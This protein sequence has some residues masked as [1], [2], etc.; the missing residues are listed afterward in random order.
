MAENILEFI[1]K[2]IKTKKQIQEDTGVVVGEPS[3]GLTDDM[4]ALRLAATMADYLMSHGMAASDTVHTVLGV[5]GRY[6]SQKVH[7]DIS[8]TILTVSQDRGIDREPLTLVRTISSRGINYENIRQLEA[9]ARKIRDG[10]ISLD[11][12]EKRLDKIIARKRLYPRW[13]SFLSAGTLS[14]GVS[15]LYSDNAFVWLA[16]FI[17]GSVV[18]ML[19]YVLAKRGVPAFYSQVAAGITVTMVATLVG[20]LAAQGAISLTEGLSPTLIVVAGIVLM[21]S[22]V[23]IVSAFQDALDEFYVTA[24]ARLLRVLM[25]TGGLVVGVTVGLYFATNHFGV[26]FHAVPEALSL[27]GIGYHYLGAFILA[28]SFALGNQLRWPGVIGV[29]LVGLMAIYVKYLMIEM[30]VG[31]IAASGVAA[32]VVG[33]SATVLLHALRVPTLATISAGVIPLVPGLILYSGMMY[34]SQSTASAADFDAGTMLLFRGVLIAV[35]VAAGATFGNLIGRP[36]RRRLIHFQNR[37][38]ERKL[39]QHSK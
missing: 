19:L 2:S 31:V 7:I 38:P 17:M 33:L 9:L 35:V 18:S 29:G 37:L 28:A 10:R 5:T 4:R 3:L 25:M 34:I 32:S 13:V 24:G 1:K 36:A 26:A 12:A 20:F 30:G 14:T 39:S 11:D 6:C 16:A 21:L 23:M 8:H 22:G 27:T 15:V